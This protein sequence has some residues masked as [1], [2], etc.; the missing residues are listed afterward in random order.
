MNRPTKNDKL[1]YKE[2]ANN[3][4]CQQG[5]KLKL[6]ITEQGHIIRTSRSNVILHIPCM[7]ILDFRWFLTLVGEQEGLDGLIT[8]GFSQLMSSLLEGWGGVCLSQTSQG[9][10]LFLLDLPSVMVTNE[11]LGCTNWIL[12]IW[13]MNQ[14]NKLMCTRPQTFH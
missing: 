13:E 2:D 3:T 7:L 4:Q 1:M 10:L 9:T 12:I 5:K 11:K 14:N 8:L 6:F